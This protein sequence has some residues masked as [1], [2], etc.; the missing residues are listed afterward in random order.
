M[1]VQETLITAAPGVSIQAANNAASDALGRLRISTIYSEFDNKQLYDKNALLWAEKIMGGATSTQDPNLAQVAMTVPAFTVASVVRQ[2]KQRFNYQT[3]KAVLDS[4]S[5]AFSAPASGIIERLG[6]FDQANGIFFQVTA[7][8]VAV[9]I[10]SSATGSPV[11]L[12]IPQSAWNLDKLD[13]TG[14]SRIVLDITKQQIFITDYQWMGAGRV[15]YGL[16]LGGIPVLVHEIDHS[17]TES[18]VYMSTPNLPSRFEI[19]NDGTGPNATLLHGCAS[20]ISE[21]GFDQIGIIRAVDRGATFIST[22][23]PNTNVIPLLSIRLKAAQTG[24]TV[25]PL[26]ASII[27]TK[28]SCFRWSLVLNPTIAGIDGATWVPL[29]DSSIEYDVSRNNTNIISG[30]TVVA[31]GYMFALE[32]AVSIPLNSTLTL[33]EDLDNIQDQFVLC[34]Q[35]T[36]SAVEHFFGALTFRELQ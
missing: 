32:S 8:G 29:S 33:G 27:S 4:F 25:I 21:G 17:N 5:G 24:T 35:N 9:G 7:A 20:V 36:T 11:D 10:R 30:G 3:G 23:G 1:A 2:T 31:S 14:P 13:G 22:G 28:G 15:R 12:I 6:I 16:Y 26:H 19:Y 34:V 18:V